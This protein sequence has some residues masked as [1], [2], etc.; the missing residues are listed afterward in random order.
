LTSQIFPAWFLIN[1]PDKRVILTS[2]GAELAF[3]FSRRVREYV[4]QHGE[5]LAGVR[6][7]RKSSAVD[8]WDLEG[9]EG[10]MIAAGVG[11]PITGHGGDL[12][13]ID[14]VIKNWV[15]ANSARYREQVWQWYTSTLYTRLEP[16]GRMVLIM[17]RW[18]QDD[19]AGRLLKQAEEGGEQW[20]ILKLPALAEKDD[21]LGRKE[22]EALWPA[23]YDAQSLLETKRVLGS[24]QFSAIYQQSPR[25]AGGNLFKREWF[26]YF[27]EEGPSYILYG[28]DGEIKRVS[29]ERCLRFQTVDLAASEKTAADYFC[30]LTFDLTPDR[31]ILVQDVLRDH[32][33]GPDQLNVLWE[34]YHKWRPGKLGIEAVAYQ[35]AFLQ[36]AIRAGLPAVK[37][38]ADRDKISRALPA[39]ARYEAGQVYH[40]AEA[41]WIADF[42]EEL[43]LFPAGE[44]DD[45]VDALAYGVLL[46]SEYEK[47]NIDPNLARLLVRAKVY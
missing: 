23:R 5:E 17:T 15:E 39:T 7:S 3:T 13:I 44:H 21:P 24:F 26:R 4:D 45:Q 42:E 11:G 41:P 37:L 12:V 28:P 14:D 29:K 31:E 30:V 43:V 47:S 36:Q 22:G 8:Q 19:L 35:L 32:I 25:A 38:K 20:E 9:Y 6:I 33:P 16:G 18:H 46:V 27:R 1:N 2:Y 40:R 10:G 34:Q